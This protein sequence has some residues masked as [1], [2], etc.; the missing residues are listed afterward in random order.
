MIPVT[1]ANLLALTVQAAVLALVGAPLPRLL[2]ILSPRARLSYFRGLLLACLMLPFIQPWLPE[3]LVDPLP[4]VR[5]EGLTSTARP[6]AGAPHAPG[7]SWVGL[8]PRVSIVDI[9]VAGTAVRLAW[10]GLGLVALARLRRRSTRLLQPPASVVEAGSLARADAEF[11]VADRPISPVTFGLIRP[12]VVVPSD[13]GDLAEGQQKAIA[14]HE[15]IHVRRRD[16]VRALADEVVRAVAWFHPA[17][18]WLTAQI[19]LSREQLVDQEAVA[20]LRARRPYLDA[21]LHL[22]ASD[23]R[24]RL[25]PVALF[26]GRTHLSER[27]S[28]LLKEVRMSRPRLAL[29][30]IG[31]AI[32]LLGTGRVIVGAFPLRG[33]PSLPPDDQIGAARPGQVTAS[34]VL[35]KKV[36]A[37]RKIHDVRP[38]FPPGAPEGVLIVLVEVDG[39]GAVTDARTVLGSGEPGSAALDAVRQWRFSPTGSP[40][41]ILVGFNAGA[42]P[43]L[44]SQPAVRIGKTVRPPVKTHDVKPIYPAGAVDAGVQGVVIMDAR[45]ATD[46]SV[47]EVMVLRSVP[48]LDPAAVAAVL[49][50]KFEPLGF[51]VEMTVTVNFTLAD[52]PSKGVAGGVKSGVPGGAKGGVPGGAGSGAGSGVGSGAGSGVGSGAGSG[53]GIGAGSATKKPGAAAIRVGT[54]LPPPKKT[55]DVMPVYPTAAREARV[56]GIVLIETTIGPDGRVVDAQVVRSI[57]ELDEAALEAVRQWEF[58]PTLLNGKAVTVVMT[59]TINFTLQ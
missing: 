31:M 45:I 7:E 18:W 28:L 35:P 47:A 48:L 25:V 16:W 17:A 40:A 4:A 1:P 26:L 32:L 33:A 34:P 41:T 43:E 27:V 29:S 2:G 55:K 24:P 46:G 23:R 59:V 5:A 42:S 11:L 37:P 8:L 15:L 52:G 44:G 53:V 56:Q 57:P 30:F 12:V 10:L 51:P 49:Q 58:T 13:F 50:W 3:P 19:R 36:A 6:I 21:L 38:A 9:V 14:C 22:A 54:N 39:T 20:L